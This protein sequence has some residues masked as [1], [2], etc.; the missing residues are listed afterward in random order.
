MSVCKRYAVR[1]GVDAAAEYH[2]A[3]YKSPDG[4]N[5]S[6]RNKYSAGY[7][8]KDYR[9]NSDAELCYSLACISE[10]KIMYSVAAEED[11]EQSCCHLRLRTRNSGSLLSCIRCKSA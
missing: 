10:I 11:S 3:L 7:C 8:R 5:K 6:K 1:I 9:S 2:Y 4:S